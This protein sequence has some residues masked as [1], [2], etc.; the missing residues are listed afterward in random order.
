MINSFIHIGEEDLMITGGADACLTPYV[1]AGFD[2]LRA[3]SRRK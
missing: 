3:M 1:F 2:V